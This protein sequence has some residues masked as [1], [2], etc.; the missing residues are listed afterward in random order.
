MAEAARQDGGGAPI[1][2]A[3]ARARQLRG[4]PAKVR[5]DE[6]AS[7][8]REQGDLRPAG[9]A[10]RITSVD[11]LRG[12]A[13]FWILGPADL[14]LSLREMTAG[15]PPPL[16]AIGAF[17]GG[18]FTHVE[19]EGLRFYDLVFP[20]F[21]FTVG[22]SIVFS[23]QRLSAREGK[24]RAH[25]R[26]ARRAVLLFGLG[27]F[28]YGGVSKLWPD[29]RL[30]GVLQRIALCYLFA[31]LLFLHLSPRGLAAALVA[32]LV[33]YWALMTFVPVPGIG[34][35]SYASDANLASWIDSRYLPG[36]KWNGAWDP[37]GLLSTLPAV[38]T[39]LIGVLAGL[40][41]ADRAL[42]PA[43]K[44][45]WL[46]VV[47]GAMLLA[48]LLWGLQ[49]PIVKN[50]WTSSFVLVTG[51]L[52]LMLLGAFHYVVDVRGVRAWATVLVW[53]GANAITLY[54]LVYVA[55]FERIAVRVVGGDVALFLDRIIAQ[56]AGRFAAHAL[57]LAMAI[58]LAGFL[59][60]RKI[61]LRV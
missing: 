14:A 23:L 49:F 51:G 59:Y 40:L 16:R 47:G 60:R 12:F 61:F 31:S 9:E 28:F 39:C 57:A 50:I 1:D 44:S 58:A 29:I 32:L 56:G 30:M 38:G 34:A 10:Q 54:L 4:D 37:E 5:V 13:L 11:V 15:A 20:L 53:L 6:P 21:V 26:V 3:S 55:N 27:L 33:G 43:R 48:G 24:L 46:I 35:A 7:R 41:L 17:I 42:A 36:H 52:S 45:L 19:W 25:L 2:F 8:P 22:V 18:Q